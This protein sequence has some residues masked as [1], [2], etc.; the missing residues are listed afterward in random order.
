MSKRPIEVGQIVRNLNTYGEVLSIKDGGWVQVRKDDG[1]IVWWGD[2]YTRVVSM[3]YHFPIVIERRPC[4]DPRSEWVFR[5]P[6]PMSEWLGRRNWH[7]D[8]TPDER[9]MVITSEVE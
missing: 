7:I 2:Y 1:E 3:A 4:F 8:F 6:R 9:Y 5:V